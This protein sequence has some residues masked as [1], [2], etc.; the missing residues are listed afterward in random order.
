MSPSDASAHDHE[1]TFGEHLEELRTRI[2]RAGL[3]VLVAA[4]VCGMFYEEA[5]RAF[6]QPYED[7]LAAVTAETPDVDRA[8]LVRFART[9]AA[10]HAASPAFMGPLAAGAWGRAFV[11]GD[12]RTPDQQEVADEMRAIRHELARVRKGRI[13]AGSPIAPY[14]TIIMMCLII[15]TMAASPWVIYQAWAF[16][17]V[18]LY[19]HERHFVYRYG[20]FS[21]VL[22]FTGVTLFYFLILPYGLQALMSVAAGIQIVETSYVLTDYAKFFAWMTLVFGLA[23]QTPIIVLFLA[24]TGI[25]PLRVLARKQRHVILL[26]CVLG[27]ILTPQD[28]VT[29][30]LLAVPLILL[31]ELGLL[32]AWIGERRAARAAAGQEAGA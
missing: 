25:V 29:M 10:G 31:Y 9:M 27:A 6:V 13:I 14:V 5:F 1:M 15:G 16:V 23:F 24:K 12:P 26:M 3:G 11:L 32:L 2:I 18:G 21:F 30:V 17:G 19:E 28:P 4:A 20:P 8:D 22:F 7:A